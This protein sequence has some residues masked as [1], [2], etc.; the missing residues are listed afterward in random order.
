P[1]EAAQR[2]SDAAKAGGDDDDATGETLERQASAL[3][4]CGRTQEALHA[5]EDA[6]ALCSLSGDRDLVVNC[7][8]TRGR[9]LRRVGRHADALAAFE[10]ALE[11]RQ[12]M[13]EQ[14][15][16]EHLHTEIALIHL[17]CG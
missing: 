13:A 9:V 15:D 8:R 10:R 17:Q 3:E 2:L 12:R 4:A 16:L 5:I 6:I 11:I 1:E 7:E 14:G